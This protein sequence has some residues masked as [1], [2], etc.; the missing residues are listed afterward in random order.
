MC[1]TRVAIVRR[2][3]NSLAAIPGFDSP[4][5]TSAAILVSVGVTLSQPFR[6]TSLRRS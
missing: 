5:P 1:E 6:G 2:D 3:S 4:A